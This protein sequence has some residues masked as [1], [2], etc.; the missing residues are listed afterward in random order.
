M[1]S[2]LVR[3][4]ELSSR[5]PRLAIVTLM[6]PLRDA[7]AGHDQGVQHPEVAG[8][9]EDA[10]GGGVGLGSGRVEAGGAAREQRGDGDGADGG[11]GR[12]AGSGSASVLHGGERSDSQPR[13]EPGRRAGRPR[14]RRCATAS[15]NGARPE[16]PRAP[17]TAAPAAQQ[18][19]APNPSP[20]PT[21]AARPGPTVTTST[22]AVSSTAPA[23]A[24]RA[25]PEPL[26]QPADPGGQ[27]GVDVR[28][29]VEEVRADAEQRAREQQPGRR[30][31]VPGQ[32]EG[33][34]GGAAARSSR[35]TAA[36]TTGA[37]DAE[38]VGPAAGHPDQV[39]EPGP[40]AAGQRQRDAGRGGQA[41]AMATTRGGTAPVTSGLSRRPAARSRPRSTRSLHQPIDSWPVSTAAATSTQPAWRAP[42][43]GRDGPWPARSPRQARQRVRQS[44]SRPCRQHADASVC[45]AHDLRKRVWDRAE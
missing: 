15:R 33:E 24:A 8:V 27:V 37:L 34:E 7:V 45:Q 39:G 2:G 10:V 1:P 30:G 4:V 11:G 18:R 23:T 29:D 22:A 5:S 6:T 25:A 42:G 13:S 32:P 44:P 35:R 16:L 40:P 17:R 14:A 43:G 31:R 3:P 12:S 41:Q 28:H 26:R 19:A 9:G 38:V 20:A 21:T 36:R